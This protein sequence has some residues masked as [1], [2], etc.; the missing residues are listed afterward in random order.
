MN[1]LKTIS[2]DIKEKLGM[3]LSPVGLL[4]SEEMPDDSLHFKKKGLGCITPLIF[5]SAKGKVVAFDND[6]T[7]WPCSSFYL[8]YSDWIFSGIEKFLSNEVV[9]G[10]EPEH[11]LKNPDIAKEFVE[12]YIP[13]E[14]RS[15][16]IV[17]KPLEFFVENEKPE[18]VIFFVNADQISALVYLVNHAAPQEERIVAKFASACMSVFTIPLQYAK[19]KKK[20]AVWGMHDI[21]VRSNMPKELMSLTMPYDL[22]L[23]VYDNI[24]D[25]F[26]MTENWQKLKRRN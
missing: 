16:A 23:E 14:K 3:Q 12:S 17:F 8:G 24:A 10:R 25:S 9:H 1:D 5:K 20:K 4:F 21:S 15:N 2:L 18:L 11:F 6:S 26:I 19:E 13:K 7:G 22:F